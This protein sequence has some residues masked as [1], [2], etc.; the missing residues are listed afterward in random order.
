M[1]SGI[2]FNE[3]GRLRQ[4]K[5]RLTA[6]LLAVRRKASSA[7]TPDYDIAVTTY[8]ARF[9][10]YFK[11]LLCQ[12]SCLFPDRRIL[13]VANGHHDRAR[14]MDYLIRLRKYVAK[15][16]NVTLIDYVVPR[17]LAK[18]WNDVIRESRSDRVLVM[19]DDLYLMPHFRSQM[20]KSGLLENKIATING[21]WSHFLITREIIDAFGWFDERFT[22]FGY[23]DVDYV[24]RLACGGIE[25]EQFEMNG[26]LNCVDQPSDYSYGTHIEISD[27]KYSGRNQQQFYKKW[28]VFDCEM[29]GCTFVP[30]LERWVKLGEPTE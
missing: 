9:D 16:P 30:M 5:W 3:L 28:R 22:E 4:W 21:S 19:N 13:V 6:C 23:E 25:A 11:S 29:P 17:G 8:I 12:L 14:Q 24:S 27:G 20:E 18:M 2:T 10:T 26:V 7:K 1:K 15:Y